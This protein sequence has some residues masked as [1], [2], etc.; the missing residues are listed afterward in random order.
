MSDVATAPVLSPQMARRPPPVPPKLR[1]ATVATAEEGTAQNNTA[2]LNPSPKV[3]QTVITTPITPART[4]P[5]TEH[6][7][8]QGVRGR[9][10]SSATPP[11]EQQDH[12]TTSA[13]GSPPT[14]SSIS[15]NSNH[16][17]VLSEEEPSSF[18]IDEISSPTETK[19]V[20]GDLEDCGPKQ[21]PED[22]IQ[23]GRD[24]MLNVEEAVPEVTVE[25]EE[26]KLSKRDKLAYEILSS[27]RS[28]VA[29]LN[30]VINVRCPQS[31]SFVV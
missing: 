26:K 5:P 8:T 9:A 21:Q 23:E 20:T 2:K 18:A 4:V 7:S 13:A 14:S 30:S 16:S 22:A 17:T 28:Y 3:S 10:S 12:I 31:F 15:R 6:T 11:D 27:E 19:E 29:A 24:D 25:N 1:R